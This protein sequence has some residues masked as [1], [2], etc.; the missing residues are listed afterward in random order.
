MAIRHQKHCPTCGR[1]LKEWNFPWREGA[2]EYHENC[3]DC[4]RLMEEARRIGGDQLEKIV[5]ILFI[6][7]LNHHEISR[8]L[9]VYLSKCE[10]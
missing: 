6:I 4:V 7:G 3:S 2:G 8:D 9:P 10:I 5:I 1:L